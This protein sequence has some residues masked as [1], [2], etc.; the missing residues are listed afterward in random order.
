MAS[1]CRAEWKGE[2]EE[3]SKGSESFS[4]ILPA[5]TE[6]PDSEVPDWVSELSAGPNINPPFPTGSWKRKKGQ[7]K[8]LICLWTYLSIGYINLELFCPYYIIKQ[9]PLSC[10]LDSF[11]LSERHWNWKE[12]SK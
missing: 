5:H 3:G 4:I 11:L 2:P 12:K 10:L 8:A 1:P 9:I 6:F 7:N